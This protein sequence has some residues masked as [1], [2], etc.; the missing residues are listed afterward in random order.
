[1][2]P[3]TTLFRS[4]GYSTQDFSLSSDAQGFSFPLVVYSYWIAMLHSVLH[5]SRNK[6][7][8]YICFRMDYW[9]YN[10]PHGNF[11]QPW[12]YQG[13]QYVLVRFVQPLPSNHGFQWA[14]V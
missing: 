10:C 1:L 9:E 3:Y 4:T 7:L 11:L 8:W 12:F 14:S 13:G 6:N 2:F 5:E